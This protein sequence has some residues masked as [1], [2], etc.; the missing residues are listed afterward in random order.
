MKKIDEKDLEL[1]VRFQK[2]SFDYFSL[3]KLK[4]F[5]DL[6]KKHKVSKET[7]DDGPIELTNCFE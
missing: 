6:T 2:G 7:S 4:D 1:D 3:E 5:E